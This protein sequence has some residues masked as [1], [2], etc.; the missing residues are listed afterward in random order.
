MMIGQDVFMGAVNNDTGAEAVLDILSLA[1]LKKIP[2]KSVKEVV[3]FPQ[4]KRVTATLDQ[5]TRANVHDSRA[6][7][8]HRSYDSILSG[9]DLVCPAH[10]VKG[11]NEMHSREKNK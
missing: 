9:I 11:R 5:L 3:V 10:T 1:G 6:H 4:V 7:F 8:P 2:E